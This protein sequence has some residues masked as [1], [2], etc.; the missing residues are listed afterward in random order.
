[1]GRGRRYKK[2]IEW[3][4]YKLAELSYM[5]RIQGPFDWLRETLG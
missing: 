5:L 3:I 2:R 4:V 1:M